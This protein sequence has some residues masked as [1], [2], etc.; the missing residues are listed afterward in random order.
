MT[1]M[2]LTRKFLAA[3]GI[4]AEKVDEIIAAHTETVNALKEE[5]DTAKA[6]AAKVDDLTK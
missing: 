6:Q 5:R 2:A 3:M 4:E 1:K